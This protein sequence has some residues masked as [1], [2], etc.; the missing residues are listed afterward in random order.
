[1]VSAILGLLCLGSLL[2]SL[3]LASFFGTCS[4]VASLI[5]SAIENANLRRRIAERGWRKVEKEVPRV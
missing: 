1:M 3:P 4:L 2:V 5:E